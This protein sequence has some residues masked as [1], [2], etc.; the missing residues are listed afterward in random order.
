MRDRY[1][2][3]EGEIS[4]KYVQMAPGVGWSKLMIF[5]LYDGA[6]ATYILQKL[7]FYLEF[8]SYPE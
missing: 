8:G 1:P 3:A 2:V 7:F 6:K 5:Q 4:G